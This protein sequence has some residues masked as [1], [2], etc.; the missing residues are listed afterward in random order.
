MAV[1]VVVVV[2]M[3]AAGSKIAGRAPFVEQ[4]PGPGSRAVSVS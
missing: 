2:A 3:A 1:V 4:T